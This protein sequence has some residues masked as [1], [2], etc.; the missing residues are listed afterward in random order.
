MKAEALA[1]LEARCFQG[2]KTWT[3]AQYQSFPDQPGALLITQVGG[4]ISGRVIADEAEVITICVAPESRQQGTGTA[5]LDEF[6]DT[7][8]KRGASKI[9]LEVAQTNTAARALYTR[10]GYTE[11]GRRKSYYQT[12]GNPPI[13]ALILQKL[14]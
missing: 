12:A 14:V 11:T 1:A 2:A 6:E 4:F 8:R 7:A 13:D 9:F 3:A 5:L 10:F